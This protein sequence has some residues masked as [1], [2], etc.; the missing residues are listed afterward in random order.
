MFNFKVVLH[1]Y[2]PGTEL[3]NRGDSMRPKPG[4]YPHP[5][6]LTNDQQH[7]DDNENHKEGV[8]VGHY[9]LH[10]A[11][12]ENLLPSVKDKMKS[13]G[14]EENVQHT[15]DPGPEQNA[16]PDWHSSPVAKGHIQSWLL[17]IFHSRVF[18]KP[19]AGGSHS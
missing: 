1:T 15:W 17:I 2:K 18:N 3:S 19:R 6:S 7:K 5:S 10:Q 16:K 4:S 11:G 13:L 14:A 8:A 9:Q 12:L